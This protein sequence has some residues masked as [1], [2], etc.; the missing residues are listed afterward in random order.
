[1]TEDPE[2]PV[3]YQISV[4]GRQAGSFFLALLVAL[5]AAFF[6]GM[7]AGQ[8]AYRG[9]DA[10]ARAAAAV[11]PA[12]PAPG[13]GTGDGEGRR[14]ASP[15]PEPGEKKLG[16]DDGPPKE[17]DASVSSPAIAP[18]EKSAEKPPEKAPEKVTAKAPEKSPEK[19][20]EKTAEK[21]VVEPTRTPEPKAAA[22]A[23]APLPARKEAPKKEARKETG[24]FFVQLMAT[25]E[26]EAADNLVKKLKEAGGFRSPDVSPVPGKPGTYRVRVGPYPD[27][28][29]AEK[30]VSRLKKEKRSA[31]PSIVK[32]DKP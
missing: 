2:G 20:K 22:P 7:K 26:P 29:A 3:H 5:G 28:A 25:K 27:H 21:K 16:F 13:Q 15:T 24:P 14:A 17:A 8:A 4:T 19:A 12:V 18:P 6:F 32:A 23:A 31:D 1:M 30:V 10:S 9:A 11:D